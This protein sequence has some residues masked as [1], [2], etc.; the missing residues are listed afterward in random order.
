VTASGSA[1]GPYLPTLL[2]LRE[3]PLLGQGAWPPD[4]RAA[5]EP[6]LLGGEVVGY[7]VRTRAGAR[8]V[9]VHAGWQTDAQAAVQ[10]VLA[11]TRRA[12]TPEPLR[13]ARTLA[14]TRRARQR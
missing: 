8:P 14:R 12:R 7:W 2:A 6:L 10:V 1:G 9:V 4:Q 13:R 11:A 5:T 3:G